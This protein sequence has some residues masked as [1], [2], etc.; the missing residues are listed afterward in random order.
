MTLECEISKDQ[1]KVE[2]F[3]GD[4]QLRRDD[5]YDIKIEGKVHRLIIEMFSDKDVA[6]YRAVCKKIYTCGKYDLAGKFT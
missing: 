1:A 2:W 3:K 4:K 5:K 6:V